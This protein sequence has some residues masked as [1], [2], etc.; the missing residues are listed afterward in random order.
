[1]ETIYL[2]CAVIGGS[3]LVLQTLLLLIGGGDADAHFDVGH[4]DTDVGQV[5]VDHSDA[6]DAFFKVLSVR[7]LVAF[8]TFFGLA[9]MAAKESSMQ[10][11]ATLLVALGA[12]TLALFVVAY[13]MAGLAHLQSEG[14][15]DLRNAVG[16][17]AHV[18]L[19][20]PGGG[21]G[22]GKVVVEVQGRRIECGAI[23]HGAE[24]PTGAE[25]K[26]VALPTPG[27]VEV[28]PLMEESVR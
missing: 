8:V 20:V 4:V 26:I 15:V 24:I 27:T 12:G 23:T 13:L 6:S 9:G 5:D 1:M 25:V 16:K 21:E 22:R 14:N 18:Y 7:T 11:S 10:P 28:Q 3:I 19:R 17:R 2:A